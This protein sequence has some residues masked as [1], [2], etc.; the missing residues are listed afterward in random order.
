MEAAVAFTDFALALFAL[1][2]SLVV[3]VVVISQMLRLERRA[4]RI[5]VRTPNRGN[6]R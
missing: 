1:L 5:P 3:P 2:G 4:L 6:K